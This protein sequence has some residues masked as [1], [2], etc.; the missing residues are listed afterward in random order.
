MRA[1]V[2]C[3]LA[4]LAGFVATPSA[5]IAGQNVPLSHGRYCGVG[6]SQMG[7]TPIDDLDKACMEHDKCWDSGAPTCECHRAFIASVRVVAD[8]PQNADVM[9]ALARNMIG[10]ISRVP[11]SEAKS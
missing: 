8:D 2:L 4:I 6:N 9:R 1:Y 10:A 7:T 11:C 3:V 5:G